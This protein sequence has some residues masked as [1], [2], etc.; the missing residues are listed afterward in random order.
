V[1][2]HP[3]AV[4]KLLKALLKATDHIRRHGEESARITAG[5]IG[6]PTVSL[7]GLD[8]DVHLSQTL[9]VSLEAQARWAIR[10]GLT[11]GTRMPDYLSMLY[12]NGLDRVKP[13]AVTVIR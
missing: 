13:G 10:N 12:V 11:D 3:K 1:K 8:F 2:A 5:A 7:S 6:T 9:V 4:E